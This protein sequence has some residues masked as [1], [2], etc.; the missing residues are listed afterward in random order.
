MVDIAETL[1]A[2]RSNAQQGQFVEAIDLCKAGLVDSGDESLVHELART[3]RAA[4]MTAEALAT[5][6]SLVSSERFRRAALSGIVVCLQATAALHETLAAAEDLRE[7][8]P[9]HAAGHA[10]VGRAL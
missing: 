1:A 4:G 3:Q 10:A 9:D 8:F 5:Y 6:R 7:A 2:I